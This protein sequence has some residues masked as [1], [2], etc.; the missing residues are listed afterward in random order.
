MVVI[1]EHRECLVA[2]LAVELAAELAESAVATS[3]LAV[4]LAAAVLLHVDEHAEV[5][6]AILA[7]HGFPPFLEH[8]VL[9]WLPRKRVDRTGP[10]RWLVHVL[11]EA[12]LCELST[13]SWSWSELEG[14]L[15]FRLEDILVA[16]LELAHVAKFEP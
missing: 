15:G 4:Q 5:G 12:N 13:E 9:P 11:F 14:R 6:S 8:A 10:F 3:V 7:D 1:V 2:E 16:V